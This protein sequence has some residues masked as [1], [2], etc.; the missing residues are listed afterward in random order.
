[1]VVVLAGLGRGKKR[2]RGDRG[3]GKVVEEGYKPAWEA[4]E[5][6][7]RASCRAFASAFRKKFL[8]AL[9]VLDSSVLDIGKVFGTGNCSVLGASRIT[10][11]S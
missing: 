2:G 3:G 11:D 8:G 10:I 4:G 7:K 5:A 9:A 6:S 1:M